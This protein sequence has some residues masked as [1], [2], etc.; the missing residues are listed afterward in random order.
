[1]CFNK[2]IVEQNIADLMVEKLSYSA[3]SKCKKTVNVL[4]KTLLKQN[5]VSNPN[6]E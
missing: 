2:R 4:V 1:M 5:N 6:P 3:P